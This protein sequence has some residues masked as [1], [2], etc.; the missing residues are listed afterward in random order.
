M[1]T[2]VNNIFQKETKLSPHFLTLFCLPTM[3]SVSL[4]VSLSFSVPFFFSFSVSHM[5]SLSPSYVSLFQSL[6]LSLLIS[7][8]ITPSCST[9]R[10]QV[11]PG[12]V[13]STC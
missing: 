6:S 13:L 3:S 10:Q 8:S 4:C 7:F 1:I 5:L 12:E 11:G 9:V 2:S